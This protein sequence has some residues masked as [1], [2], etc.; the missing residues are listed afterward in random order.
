L[1]LREETVTE[2]NVAIMCSK[3]L[4]L[5]SASARLYSA[6]IEKKPYAKGLFKKVKKL[7]E[8]ISEICE[9]LP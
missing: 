6:L 4:E 2:Q 8:E 7:A 5:V 3:I 1:S 9:E